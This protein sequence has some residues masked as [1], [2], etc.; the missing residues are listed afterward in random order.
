M[1]GFFALFV[2]S[3]APVFGTLLTALVSWGAIEFTKYVRSKTKSEVAN[4]AISQICH[5][6]K[7]TVAELNQTMVSE[8]QKAA[9][10]GKITKDEARILKTMAVRKIKDQIPDAVERAAKLSVNSVSVLIDGEVEKAVGEAKNQF[11]C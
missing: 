1:E 3:F 9:A 2:N 6:A 8:M 5:I 10:D 7:T 11:E 4:A